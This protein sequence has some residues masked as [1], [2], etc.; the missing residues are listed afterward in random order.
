MIED[1]YNAEHGLKDLL[2]R[3]EEL[4]VCHVTHESTREIEH[5][6]GVLRHFNQA[7]AECIEELKRAEKAIQCRKAWER[8]AVTLMEASS[9]P[10]GTATVAGPEQLARIANEL[11]EERHERHPFLK[12]IA[13]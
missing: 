13:S 12:R 11:H 8:H 9:E 10:Q 4:S 1:E 3:D 6:T 2:R 5:K 7:N